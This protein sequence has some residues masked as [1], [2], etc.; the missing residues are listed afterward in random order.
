M[1][2]EIKKTGI[3]NALSQHKLSAFILAG[4][5]STRMGR[6]KALIEVDGVPLI[7]H[8][9]QI[10]RAVTTEVFIIGPP[11]KFNAMPA[12]VFPD[13]VE[14]H[15]PLSG[16]LTA[17]KKTSSVQNLV[18]AADMP[19][20]SVHFIR[21]L[22]EKSGGASAVIYRHPDG[23]VEP[24]CGI[25]AKGILP[26][27][28]EAY[29]KGEYSMIS[30]LKKMNVHWVEKQDLPA[31]LQDTP[32]FQNINTPSDLNKVAFKEHSSGKSQFND[33]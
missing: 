12:T 8:M 33:E 27:A 16:L 30:L 9:I 29:R 11:H 25:Y 28:E 3:G 23:K 15:G 19:F 31:S 1:E 24:L 21:F 10:A 17:L 20:V 4:G 2:S 13:I 32:L 7:R 26:V 18:L 6:D 22:L 14:P 5:R